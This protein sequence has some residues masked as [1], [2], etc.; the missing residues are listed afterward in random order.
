M[1]KPTALIGILLSSRRLEHSR[2]S[3]SHL[4]V[5]DVD[6]D[7]KRNLDHQINIDQMLPRPYQCPRSIPDLRNCTDYP[8]VEYFIQWIHW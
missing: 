3:V 4:H 8:H 1:I 7:V 2:I 6:I 5:Q